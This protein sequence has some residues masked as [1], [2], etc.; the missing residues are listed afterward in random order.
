[1]LTTRKPALV[2]CIRLGGVDREGIAE[3]EEKE[4]EDL[5][6]IPI[7]GGGGHPATIIDK[8]QY[9]SKPIHTTHQHPPEH[10]VILSVNGNYNRCSR[11]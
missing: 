11:P 7:F 9:Q 6:L 1:M 5:R 2:G 4:G 10:A 8:I 3:W